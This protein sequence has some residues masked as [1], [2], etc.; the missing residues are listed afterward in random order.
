MLKIGVGAGFSGDRFEP[1]KVLLEKASLDYLILEC[2]AERTIAIAQQEKMNNENKGYDP[3]LERRIRDLLPLLKKHKVRM[4]TNMGAANP[5]AGAEKI[6][7]ISKELGIDCK[8]AVVIGDNVLDELDLDKRDLENQCKLSSYN[9]LISAN[10]YLGIDALLPALE[11]DADIIITG[12][13]ADPSLFLAPQV[14]YYNWSLNDYKKLGQGT[15]I[16][17]LLECAGQV[18]GGYFADVHKKTVPNL[19]NIGFP[20][21]K[22]LADGKAIITKVKGTGG[23]IDSRTIKEQLL[24][25]IHNP[26]EY[27]TPD[28]IADLSTVKIKE[29]G[30]DQVEISNGSGRKRTDYLKVSV[31]YHAGYNSVGEISYAGKDALERAKLAGSIIKKRLKDKIE[32][33]Q[34]DYIGLSS[35]HGNLFYKG[36][37]PYEV[38]LRVSGKHPL[39]HIARLVGEEVEALYLNGPAG[40]G[41]ARKY[42]NESIGVVSTLINR[43]KVN[44][45][46]EL[47]D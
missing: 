32:D 38:R 21:A 45:E 6:I 41:G 28:T 47:L 9:S 33:L 4:I 24:Y 40:G 23:V 25:E 7:E 10:A 1:A 36:T 22:I 20:Y 12:R 46:V 31:S 11:S 27:I 5:R 39:K 8:V 13:V 2:L 35:L 42:L 37:K 29:I 44:S 34:I 30:K 19:E 15:I 26:K 43:E 16:G 17:H 14:Y 3:L 18:T